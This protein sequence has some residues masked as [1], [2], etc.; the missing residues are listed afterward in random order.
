[1]IKRSIIDTKFGVNLEVQE[2]QSTRQKKML[3]LELKKIRSILKKGKGQFTL[4][5][6]EL[7]DAIDDRTLYKLKDKPFDYS[8]F[9]HIYIP[10]GI[11]IYKD[12][13]RDRFDEEKEQ[14]LAA[15]NSGENDPS[16]INEEIDLGVKQMVDKFNINEISHFVLDSRLFFKKYQSKDSLEELQ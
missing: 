5:L 10:F 11:D 2:S 12:S 14:L 9:E 7:D 13:K 16:K 6:E 15:M 3:K 8:E 1:M 4:Q